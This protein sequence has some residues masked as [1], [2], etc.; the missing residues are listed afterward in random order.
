[1]NTRRLGRSIELLLMIRSQEMKRAFQFFAV[2]ASSFLAGSTATLF[3]HP[4]AGPASFVILSILIL[5]CLIAAACAVAEKI[6]PLYLI[7]LVLP[8]FLISLEG[9]SL[10]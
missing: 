1:M 6:L 4:G 10:F 9:A 3:F 8:V 7:S 5:F 2:G